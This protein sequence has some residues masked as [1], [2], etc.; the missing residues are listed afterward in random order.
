MSAVDSSSATLPPAST[1]TPTPAP[2]APGDGQDPAAQPPVDDQPNW[3]KFIGRGIVNG[4]DGVT[5]TVG[6]YAALYMAGSTAKNFLGSDVRSGSTFFGAAGSSAVK[7]SPALVSAVIGPAMADGAAFLAP[8]LIPKYQPSVTNDKKLWIRAE[9]AAIGGVAV[10]LAAGLIWMKWPNLLKPQ[11]ASM[12][13][14]AA[15][16]G[17]KLNLTVFGH[18]LME[19]TK[20]V[21]PMVKSG[22]FSN[23]MTIGLVGGAATAMLS[24]KAL[25]AEGDDRKKWGMAAAAAGA[26]TIGGIGLAGKLTRGGEKA[27]RIAF[28]PENGFVQFWKPNKQWFIDYASKVAP[29]T[30]VPAGTAA[31]NNFTVVDAFNQATDARS[32]Y[33]STTPTTPTRPTTPT[34]PPRQPANGNTG[35]GSG[36]TTSTPPANGQ[37][38]D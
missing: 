37:T 17:G 16:N 27:S 25:G 5:K 6:P 21:A 33:R 13:T 23:R 11:G 26:L 36:S 2:T 29:I 15:V 12:I 4:T 32:P 22:A 1:P 28:M 24:S 34:T 35:T 31:Y 14:D 38:R 19:G 9:R 30:A 8:N 3:Q 7:V 20:D 10:A 18:T